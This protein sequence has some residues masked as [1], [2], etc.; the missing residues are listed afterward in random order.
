M[1]TTAHMQENVDDRARL[2]GILQGLESL[3]EEFDMPV[4]FPIHPRSGKRIQEFGISTNGS[5][6][7]IE[8]VDFFKLFAA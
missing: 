6:R 3:A 7:L 1:L 5:I 4:I 2:T 8:P